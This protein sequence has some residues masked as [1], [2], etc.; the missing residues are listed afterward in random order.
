MTSWI[1]LSPTQHQNANFLPRTDFHFCEERLAVPV[2]LPELMLLLPHMVLGIQVEEQH[3]TPVALLALT[4][5]QPLYVG[6]DGGWELPYIPA[7][8]RAHPFAIK[9][10]EQGQRALCLHE[11]HL[12]HDEGT[13]LF[14]AE[15]TLND[16]VAKTF[17]FLERCEQGQDQARMAAKQLHAAGVLEQWPLKIKSVDGETRPFPLSGLHRV[18][19]A[20]LNTLD[21]E[22]YHSLRGGPMALAHAQM[23]SMAQLSQLARHAAERSATKSSAVPPNVAALFEEDNDLLFDFDSK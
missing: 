14:T 4:P 5:K 13:P 16:P 15:G 10:T 1:A 17:T 20:A 7:M 3:C 18:N 9:T 6:E 12:S 11:T 8:L 23:F 2:L 22:T 19:E 21:S